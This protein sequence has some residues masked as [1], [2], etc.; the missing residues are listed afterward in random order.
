MV[1]IVDGEAA[2]TRQWVGW[3]E[4]HHT[5][6]GRRQTVEEIG[7]RT[8]GAHPIIDHLDLDARSSLRCQQIAEML[9]VVSDVLEDVVLEQQIAVRG[10]NRCE[11]RRKRLVAIA[12]DLHAVAGDQGTLGD[13]LL[14]RQVALERPSFGSLSRQAGQDGLGL[15]CRQRTAGAQHLDFPRWASSAVI[16]HRNAGA[17]RQPETRR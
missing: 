16:Y 4:L 5:H 7:R 17:P 12:Q 6:A 13:G 2:P 10:A 8:D 11:H 9:A 14:E 3:I 1:A 15:A